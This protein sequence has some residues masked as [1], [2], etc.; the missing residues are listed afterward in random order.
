MVFSSFSCLVLCPFLPLTE[1]VFAE[2][3]FRNVMVKREK[4]RKLVGHVGLSS[5]DVPQ[6]LFLKTN[7][8]SV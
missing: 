7:L 5:L 4:L 1:A 6:N 8:F 3:L 2:A